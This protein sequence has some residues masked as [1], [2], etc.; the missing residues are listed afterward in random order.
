MCGY[1]ASQIE[2]NDKYYIHDPVKARTSCVYHSL[3]L[4][5]N[6]PKSPEL[7]TNHLKLVESARNLKKK[8]KFYSGLDFLNLCNI[9]L[10]FP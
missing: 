7:F 2:A 8:C 1:S 10:P 6:Y 3:A 9:L 5:R 4:S